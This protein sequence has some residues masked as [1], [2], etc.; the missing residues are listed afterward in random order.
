MKII[1]DESVS[2]GEEI[3]LIKW[4]FNSY[5]ISNFKGRLV[6]ISTDHIKVR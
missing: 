2:Y 1:V 4:F 6:T 3:E 5:S